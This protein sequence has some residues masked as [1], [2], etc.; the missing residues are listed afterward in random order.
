M[1]IDLG[2]QIGRDG[3]RYPIGDPRLLVAPAPGANTL[4][5]VQASLATK[6]YRLGFATMGP[7]FTVSGGPTIVPDLSVPADV[8]AGVPVRIDVVLPF[9]RCTVGVPDAGAVGYEGTSMSLFLFEDGD[10][11]CASNRSL[12]TLEISP[13]SLS[14]PRVPAPGFHVYTLDLYCTPATTVVAYGIDAFA[15]PFME[16]SA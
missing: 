12:L 16:V 10:L 6:S 5:G 1:D 3:E 4:G 9:V 13:F 11:I 7:T 8:P 15:Y 14:L 2:T